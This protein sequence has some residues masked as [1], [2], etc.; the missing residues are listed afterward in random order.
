MNRNF[1]FII[2]SICSIIFLTSCWNRKELNELAIVIG[3]GID[4]E[5]GKFIVTAQVVNPGEIAESQGTSGNSPVVIYQE[6]GNTLFEAIRRITTVSP[7]NLYFSHLRLLV[8]GEELAKKGIGKTLDFLSRDPEMRTDFYITV[9]KNNKAG[10]ILKIVTTM[11]KIPVQQL[12]DSLLTSEKEWAPTLPITLDQLI[13]DILS[14]GMNAKLTGIML[15]G[16]F[17]TGETLEN[18]QHSKPAAFL[19]YDAIGVF[20][21]DKL[22][23][24][25][26]DNESKGLNYALGNVKDT[27]VTLPCPKKGTTDIELIHTKADLKTK[28][29]NHKPNGM[30]KILAE[31]NVGNVQ[32]KTLDLTKPETISHLEIKTEKKIQQ[33]IR[34]ALN[35]SQKK[36]RIDP[37]GFG[38]AARRSN[39][40]YWHLIK[41]DW[42]QIFETMPV[43]IEVTV[44]LHDIGMIKN[45]P[46]NKI[47]DKPDS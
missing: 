2:I 15:K 13:Y 29:L 20:R 25:L 37:F 47:K 33:N 7:R 3:M 24:W 42:I 40:D 4:I 11:E 21:K 23:G 38:E 12:F 41:N 6:K 28:I 45:S 8:F 5:D 39:P 31:G 16:N 43:E 14:E 34:M 30:I 19:Q 32:C 18:T 17:Q 22:I 27:I 26:Q 35:A 36:Y 9:A 46:L 1:L 10:D 44:N